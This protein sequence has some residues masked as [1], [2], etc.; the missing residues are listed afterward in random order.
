MEDDERFE[1]LNKIHAPSPRFI[2]K[3]WNDLPKEIKELLTKNNAIETSHKEGKDD[4]M[5]RVGTRNWDDS[6]NKG[7]GGTEGW[8]EGQQ[9]KEDE[10]TV[11]EK[12]EGQKPKGGE[13]E[14]LD[15]GHKTQGK[16]H[17]KERIE[18]NPEIEPETGGHA[19]G[20]KSNCSG[21]RIL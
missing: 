18:T 4:D 2:M 6:A 15:A 16:K 10:G 21:R 9:P 19:K 7:S 17:K 8:E 13:T 14:A 12:I 20:Q 1:A 3:S 11:G 5:N